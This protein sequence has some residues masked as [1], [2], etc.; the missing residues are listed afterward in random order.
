VSA[1]DHSIRVA[2]LEIYAEQKGEGS[3]ALV[4]IPHAEFTTIDRIGNLSTP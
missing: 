2:H 4:F 3:P 1:Q